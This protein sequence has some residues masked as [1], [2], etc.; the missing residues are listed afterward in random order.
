MGSEIKRRGEGCYFYI[1][2]ILWCIGAWP[3]TV[4]DGNILAQK[5]MWSVRLLLCPALELVSM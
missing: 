3:V 1:P 2:I 4:R 5:K